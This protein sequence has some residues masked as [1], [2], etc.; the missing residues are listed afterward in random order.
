MITFISPAKT[1]DFS[2]ENKIKDCSTPALLN[3]SQELIKGL[4]KLKTNDLQKLMSISEKLAKLNVERFSDWKL[5]MNEKESRPAIYA[6]KGDVYL[7]IDIEKLKNKEVSYLQKN[8][9]ILSGLYGVLKPLD[10][11]LPY[12]LEMGTEFK[13]KKGKNLYAFWKDIL[14]Q[15]II[16]D[17]KLSEK[18]II[19]NLASNE[20][21]KALDNKTLKSNIITPV[22][23]DWSNGKYKVISFHA[24]KA[25]G[26]MCRYMAINN[27]KKTDE[28]KDFDLEGYKFDSESSSEEELVYLRKSA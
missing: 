21:F 25:R 27:I 24:K 8:I 5:P 9:R 26:L 13:N 17:D 1:L 12:R 7:G 14:C 10:N 19:V 16:D 18:S 28:L 22:F 23:K 3:H 6:F 11:I 15:H 4:K 20:Y 2:S